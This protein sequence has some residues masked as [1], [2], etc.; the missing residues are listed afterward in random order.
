M[1]TY[2]ARAATTAI[3][4]D[5][6]P[7]HDEVFDEA[8]VIGAALDRMHTHI[9]ATRDI[10]QADLATDELLSALLRK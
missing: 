1:T 5:Y 6:L 4:G 9:T 3:V 10:V 8:L 7:A 2:T